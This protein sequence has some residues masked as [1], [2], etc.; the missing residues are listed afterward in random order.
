LARWAAAAAL[1]AGLWRAAG[2]TRPGGDEPILGRPRITAAGP[3]RL[4]FTARG[5]VWLTDAIRED[6]VSQAAK[7]ATGVAAAAA[8]V[9][10][11]THQDRP[12]WLPDG[13]AVALS[14]WT[15]GQADL[16]VYA[17]GLVC[18]LASTPASELLDDVAPDGRFLFER[19]GM[20]IEMPVTPGGD[21]GWKAGPERVLTRGRDGRY[22]PDGRHILF[23][24]GLDHEPLGIWRQGY[25][26]GDDSEIYWLDLTD[27][28]VARLTENPDN[29]EM[30]VPLDDAGRR[31]IACRERGSAYQP[32]LVDVLTPRVHRVRRL[33]NPDGDWPVVFPAVRRGAGGDEL[34]VWF[35]AD[36][37]LFRTAGAVRDT[38][39]AFSPAVQVSVVLPG[40]TTNPFG[41][42]LFRETS[43]VLAA[44]RQTRDRWRKIPAGSRRRFGS[45][46]AR[47]A[48]REAAAEILARLLGRMGLP[49]LYYLPPQQ[50]LAGEGVA[51]EALVDTALSRALADSG[52]AYVS[53]ARLDS[54]IASSLGSPE[55]ARASAVVLDLRGPRGGSATNRD[56][57]LSGV[58]R[59]KKPIIALVSADTYGESEILA[60]RLRA[61][62][63]RLVG[64]HTAGGL[65]STESHVLAAGG[66]LVV[67]VDPTNRN[68]G[69]GTFGDS[70]FGDSGFGDS[71]LGDRGAFGARG[72]A[73]NHFVPEL[74]DPT[75]EHWLEAVLT[76]RRKLLTRG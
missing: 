40:G 23:V 7:V 62:G 71:G 55:V 69:S 34:E 51:P 6:S 64:R 58:A 53:A 39:L 57:I 5:R 9:P 24:R 31:F 22:T 13:G 49:G 75:A 2:C 76:A 68:G 60:D 29:D 52:L 16:A 4:A 20:L 35:E 26:G 10:G 27:H 72:M 33:P 61:L 21:C 45:E 19:D 42:E 12:V 18:R 73:P 54:E 41:R 46:L 8:A 38:G 63:A 44:G 11:E 28:A 17:G 59:L 37:R 36:G 65:I 14:L 48:S 56:R 67:P 66:T 15:D 43:R 50:S 25:S 74:P 47:A 1:L 32:W 3:L 70:G 30:P